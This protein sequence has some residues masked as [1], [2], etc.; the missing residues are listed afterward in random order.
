MLWLLAFLAACDGTSTCAEDEVRL[1]GACLPYEAGTPVAFDGVTPDVGATWQWQITGLLDATWEVEVY[2]IDPWELQGVPASLED[3][4]VICYFSAGSY[5]P[6]RP[7]ADLF[8]EEDIGR[9][10]QG[11]PDEKWLDITSSEVRSVMGARITW[12]ASQGCDAVEPDNVTAFSNNTGFGITAL[13]QLDYNK[14]L[15]DTAHRLGIA[16]ALKNDLEQIGDLLPWFDFAVNEECMTYDECSELAPFIAADKPVF[17]A[18]YVDDFDDAADLAEEVCGQN[19][20]FS[21][22]I[23]TWDLGPELQACP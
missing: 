6:W 23:K 4:Y 1:D 15:A 17:H 16:V 12:A 5:E 22:I 3:R 9:G 11:W 18:E 10:L 20:G 19:P 8:R 2:D 7:D 13:E 21:T 14:F